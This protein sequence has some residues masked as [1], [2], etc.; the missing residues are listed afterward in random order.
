ME[1]QYIE[2]PVIRQQKTKALVKEIMVKAEPNKWIIESTSET[3]TRK[4]LMAT[5]QKVSQRKNV[6]AKYPLEWAIHESETGYS[7][8]VRKL[9]TK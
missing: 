4:E 1:L 5:Q 7:I 2:N 8:I 6:Y 9:E 3:K